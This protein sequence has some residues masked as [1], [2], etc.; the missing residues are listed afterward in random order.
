MRRLKKKIFYGLCGGTVAVLAIVRACNPGVVQPVGECKSDSVSVDM[1]EVVQKPV[2]LEKKTRHRVMG[3]HSYEECFP[4]LQEVQILAAQRWGVKPVRNREEA[5]RRKQDLVYVGANPNFCID[6]AMRQSIP[7]LVPRA[8]DLLQQI[9]RNF[10]DSLYV[11]DVPAHRIIVSSVLRT[12]DDVARLRRVNGNASEQSC[13]RYGTTFDITYVRFDPV[14][15]INGA[16]CE[17]V[18]DA[19]LKP[20]LSEVLRDLRQQG[21]CYVKHERKQSCFHITVR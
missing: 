2:V 19:I 1:T 20:V 10:I 3:V 21:R 15:H 6:R 18:S 12:E 4:D 13:H 11:K 9:G 7:Y 17:Y 8:S 14:H 5:E 16:P